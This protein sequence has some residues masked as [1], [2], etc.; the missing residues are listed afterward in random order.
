MR[1][2]AEKRKVEDD[3]EAE[4][5]LGVDKDALLERSKKHELERKVAS[6]NDQDELVDA[7]RR[8]AA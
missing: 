2:E 8:C 4:R 7:G 5:V 6:T 1:L 3:L